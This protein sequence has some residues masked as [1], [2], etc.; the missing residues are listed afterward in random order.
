MSPVWVDPSPGDGLWYTTVAAVRAMP[1]VPDT[2]PP[3]DAD[4]VARII[5]AE[6]WIDEQLGPWDV[7]PATGRKISEAVIEPWRFAKLSRATARLAARLYANPSLLEPDRYE[8]VSGPDFSRSKP[9]KPATRIPDVIG[10]LNASG[11]R[12]LSARARC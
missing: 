8:S 10:P 3:S 7:D 4:L 2:A 11:L 9:R 5:E 6:D 1:E 12:I